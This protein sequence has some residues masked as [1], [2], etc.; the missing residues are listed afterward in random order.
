MSHNAF[1]LPQMIIGA[2]QDKGGIQSEMQNQEKVKVSVYLSENVHRDLKIASFTRGQTL[3]NTMQ[4]AAVAWLDPEKESVNAPGLRGPAKNT[5][6]EMK[7][8]Q[9]AV[10]QIFESENARAMDVCAG[11]LEA[12]LAYIEMTNSM[13]EASASR[14]LAEAAE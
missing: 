3:Q 5:K 10:R 13:G 4:A 11:N 12:L 2:P 14:P 7:R 6:K 9:Q 1:E 8:W